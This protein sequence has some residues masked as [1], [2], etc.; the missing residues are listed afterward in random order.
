MN[1]IE[2][3]VGYENL[4]PHDFEMAKRYLDV[5]NQAADPNS[6]LY[7]D[8]EFTSHGISMCCNSDT[9]I[10]GILITGINPGYNKKCNKGVFYSFTET[11]QKEELYKSSSY[12]RNKEKQ[13]FNK[14]Y[15][16]L[17]KTAYI[18]LFPYA[19]SKQKQFIKDILPNIGFQVKTLEITLDEIERLRPRLVIAANTST[20]FY[21]GITDAT[22]LGYNLEKVKKDKMPQC[23]RNTKLRLYRIGGDTGYKLSDDRVGQDKYAQKSNLLNSFFIEYGLYDER[24]EKYPQYLLTP[25]ILKSLYQEIVSI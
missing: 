11:M 3:I 22:W 25:D 23:I 9:T 8:A 6:N 18:D 12:W 2:D 15:S 13:F 4:S 20:S 21:W 1:I 5:L 10:G 16:L 7:V 24:M 17:E 19:Q 14:D